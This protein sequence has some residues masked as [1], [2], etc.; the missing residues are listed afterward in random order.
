ML[1]GVAVVLAALFAIIGGAYFVLR[2]V[3]LRIAVGPPGSDDLKVI[4]SIAQA[5][6]RERGNVRLRTVVTDGAVASAA[7]LDA[8]TAD[9][10]VVR[11]DLS[12]PKNAQ[13][14]AVLRKNVVVLWAPLPAAPAKGKPR[15]AAIKKIADLAGRRVGVVGR[16]QANVNM[17]RVILAQYG[18]P[19]DKVEILQF[20]T[21]E[22]AEAAR[23]QK[24]DAFLAVGPM[25]SQITADAIAASSRNGPPRFLEIDANEAITQRYPHY[26]TSEITAG[27]FGSAPARPD[28]A[29]KTIS[30][31]HHL[32]ARASLSDSVVSSFTRALFTIRQ[33]IANE[34][35]QV[36]KIETPDTD[37]DAVIP[38]HPGAAAYVDGEEKSFAE[39]YS[40]L[41]YLA[42][43][44]V[45]GIGS[46]TAWFASYLRKENRANPSGLRE[47]LL[48]ILAQARIAESTEELDTLQI[49]TDGLLRH[50][51][52]GYEV[53]AIEDAALTVYS[54]V[55]QQ[56]LAAIADR[57]A[58]L[59]FEPPRQRA[60]V[61]VLAPP[62]ASAGQSGAA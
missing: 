31:A 46:A 47:R 50:I 42:L 62:A 9:L 7:A 29:V 52:H 4:Q 24:V 32:V 5:L 49:E 44:V 54:L 3:S 8:G 1:I 33:T 61:A 25:N 17:L 15:P 18:V 13:A 30:V 51:L 38:A 28:D 27:A 60:T 23:L 16:T 43:I 6:G 2:P 36:S 37:K 26:E 11:G 12:I 41:M 10:A 21:S 39:R 35:P 57:R 55:L 53:G 22:V 19:A 48:D 58:V 45:S 20:G 14:V 40:D 34:L 56:A 59:A